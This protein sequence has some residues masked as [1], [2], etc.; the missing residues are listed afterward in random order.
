LTPKKHL[1]SLDPFFFKVAAP[2]IAKPNLSLLPGKVPIAWKAATVCCLF[3]GR[4]QADP[5]CYRPISILPCL[6]NV[7]EKRVNNHLT[8]FLDVY[9]I[10]SGMQSG[11]HSGYGCV[12]A[13][14]KVLNDVTIVLDS[15]QYCAAVLLTW[16]KI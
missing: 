2:I 4:D 13:T 6:S 1:G 11:F 16:P 15:K 5:N 8:G 12:T 14:L 9:S 3:K 7:L 10:L